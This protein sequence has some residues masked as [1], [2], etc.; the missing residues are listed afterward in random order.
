MSDM[1][2]PPTFAD[3][4][5]RVCEACKLC[6]TCDRCEC[7]EVSPGAALII[8]RLRAQLRRATHSCSNPEDSCDVDCCAVAWADEDRR[9]LKA[10]NK[11]LLARRSVVCGTCRG[12]ARVG[13]PLR[14]TLGMTRKPCPDCGK[15]KCG[16]GVRWEP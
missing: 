9:K 14:D 6:R 7:A 16:P 2:I 15:D 13:T 4:E 10:E 1:P 11:R 12:T 5:H 8:E 3:G